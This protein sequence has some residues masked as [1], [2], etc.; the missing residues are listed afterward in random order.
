MRVVAL[1]ALLVASC[2]SGAGSPDGGTV[3]AS[4]E[5][6][7]RPHGEPSGMVLSDATASFGEIRLVS[8]H[9]EGLMA[10]ATVD[11]LEPETVIDLA[12][13]VP[14]LYSRVRLRLGPETADTLR[15]DAAFGMVNL[16]MRAED[17]GEID[18]RCPSGERLDPGG[19]LRIDVD[20]DRGRWFQGIDLESGEVEDGVLSLDPESGPNR[21]LA[22]M[23]LDSILGSFSIEGESQDEHRDGNEDGGVED[24]DGGVED[25]GED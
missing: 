17:D 10:A 19:H 16:E 7:I 6:A 25:G 15:V 20:V 22:E 18:L 1:I 11:L 13:A 3:A 23:A 24:H 21:D 4:L 14:G 2:D 9:G 8:D 5:L 12:D